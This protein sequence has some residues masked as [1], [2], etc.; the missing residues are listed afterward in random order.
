MKILTYKWTSFQSHH[1]TTTVLGDIFH[2][3]DRFKLPMH[4]E[5]KALFFRS[6]RAAIF[7]MN[8]SDVDEVEEVLA[9]KPGTSWEKKMAFDFGYIASRVRRQVPPPEV[10]YHRMS[11]VFDFFK[12]KIDSQTN[13]ILFNNKNKKKFQNMLEMVKNGYASDPPNLAMYITKTDN[14][15]RPMVD[16]DGHTLSF[17]L[18]YK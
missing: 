16:K 10:L 4:N 6:L 11:V 5:Y 1:A 7:I 13:V 17:N 8:K 9:T 3:V 2:F 14:K 18:W 15:G 12:D